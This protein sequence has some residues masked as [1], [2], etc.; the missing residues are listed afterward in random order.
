MHVFC[1]LN[2]LAIISAIALTG[3]WQREPMSADVSKARVSMIRWWADGGRRF[4]SSDSSERPVRVHV[5]PFIN[6]F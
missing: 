4:F 2:L 3:E 5:M 1:L 6:A